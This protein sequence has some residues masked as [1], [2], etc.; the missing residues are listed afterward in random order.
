MPRIAEKLG[1]MKVR[2]IKNC[3]KTEIGRKAR[4]KNHVL[5]QI[6]NKVA[7]KVEFLDS[8]R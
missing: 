6:L 8:S 5:V 1:F 3:I 4:H 2:T 7:L